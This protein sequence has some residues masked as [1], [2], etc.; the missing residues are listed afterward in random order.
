MHCNFYNNVI[1]TC[2]MVVFYKF[3]LRLCNKNNKGQKYC[4]PSLAKHMMKEKFNVS[5]YMVLYTHKIANF[6]HITI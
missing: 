1:T 6:I 2:F 4:F 3:T 5:N